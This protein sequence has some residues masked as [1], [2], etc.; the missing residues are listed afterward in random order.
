MSCEAKGQ[1]S[2]YDSLTLTIM[3]QN[4]ASLTSQEVEVTSAGYQSFTTTVASPTNGAIGAVTFYSDGVG[5]FDACSVV[6]E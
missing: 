5:T 2:G 4:Y 1:S 3:D 6:Q